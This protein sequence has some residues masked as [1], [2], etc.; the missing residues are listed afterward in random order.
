MTTSRRE[1]LAASAVAVAASS[2]LYA[3]GNDVLKVGLIGCGARGTG[4]A[5]QALMADKNVK[6][7]AMADAFEDRLNESL[8]N[9]QKKE[10]LANKIDV[11]PDAK[12]VGFDGYKRVIEMCDVVLLCTPPQFRPLHLKAAVEAGKH[13]FAEKPVAVDAPGVRSVLQS[14]AEAKKKNLSVVSGLCLR[15]DSGF[16]GDGE[17]HPRWRMQVMWS[18][19]S[20]TTIAAAGGR[21]NAN[22][23]GPT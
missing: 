2:S 19:Y 17:T 5:G 6:L 8:E 23:T 16:Q 1:F 15:F 13:V 21:R 4:A 3:A 11:K 10:S 20:P 9:L 7:V 22:R 18:R 12:F 14:C